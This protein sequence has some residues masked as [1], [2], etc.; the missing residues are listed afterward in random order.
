M[1]KKYQGTG[2]GL[3]LTRLI[4]ESQGGRVGVES[5]FGKGSTFSAILPYTLQK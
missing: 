4:V 1:A 5:A 2:L 3:V